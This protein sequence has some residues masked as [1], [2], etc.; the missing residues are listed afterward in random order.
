MTEDRFLS[1]WSRRKTRN[2]KS[3]AQAVAAPAVPPIEMSEEDPEA[4]P[5]IIAVD[6]DSPTPRIEE[7]G[8]ESAPVLTEEELSAKAEELGLP[9]LDSLGPGSDFKAFMAQDVP[10]QLRSLALRRLWR[11]NPVLANVDGLVDYGEDFTD[12]ATVVKN[13]QTAYQVGKGYRRDPEPEEEPDDALEEGQEEG[14]EAGD[15]PM[16]EED[17]VAEEGEEEGAKDEAEAASG[18]AEKDSDPN[19]DDAT[20]SRVT[21]ASTDNA[22]EIVSRQTMSETT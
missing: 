3:P 22:D 7:G 14:L 2:R 18:T 5:G 15:D 8:E 11:S 20:D 13:M 6:P 17:A 9:D 4:D 10:A 1:R 19:P 16:V 12:A 21:D